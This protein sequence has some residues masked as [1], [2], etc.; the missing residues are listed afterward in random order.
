[1]GSGHE[2][3]RRNTSSFPKIFQGRQH[4]TGLPG[5]SLFRG[6]DPQIRPGQFTNQGN[7]KRV[8]GTA[9]H[10]RVHAL[11]EH[12][13]ETME[14]KIARVRRGEPA[15]LDLLD[16]AGANLGDHAAVR[17]EPLHDVG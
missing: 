10:Q 8:V 2:T 6:D 1:M 3:V 7:D 9:Q 14:Q 11:F 17:C 12:R 4:T 5:H 13:I 15:G 16:E